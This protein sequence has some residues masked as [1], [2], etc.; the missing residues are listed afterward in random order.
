MDKRKLAVDEWVV[1]RD[2]KILLEGA[3]T[4]NGKQ[5]LQH[6][7]NKLVENPSDLVCMEIYKVSPLK[8][9]LCHITTEDNSYN[10]EDDKIF[11][12]SDW[13]DIKR[14]NNVYEATYYNSLLGECKEW[15]STLEV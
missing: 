13:Y 4:P 2:L 3:K 14:L 1:V 5:Y 15:R 11:F 12:T 8:F 6:T 9:Q 10:M 7:L